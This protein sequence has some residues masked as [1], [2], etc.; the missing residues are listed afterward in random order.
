[1]L[2]QCAELL[3]QPNGCAP[4]AVSKGNSR[5]NICGH[6]AVPKV[7]LQTAKRIRVAKIEIVRT[8]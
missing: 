7:K 5:P 4:Q 2:H 8:E 6:A 3:E 1:M